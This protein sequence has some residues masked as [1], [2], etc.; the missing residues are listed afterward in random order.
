[1]KL[2]KEIKFEG[3]K[4]KV[5]NR[6]E[7]VADIVEYGERDSRKMVEKL[8]ETYLESTDE[9]ES[10]LEEEKMVKAKMEE[11]K[12]EIDKAEDEKNRYKE[13]Y[14]A[15]VKRQND[16]RTFIYS[17]KVMRKAQSYSK[18]GFKDIKH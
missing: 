1:M 7:V 13:L 11:V 4:S 15:E 5:L 16:L 17:Q 9:L 18:L 14:M 3:R 2:I 6:P 10:C 8:R 12:K